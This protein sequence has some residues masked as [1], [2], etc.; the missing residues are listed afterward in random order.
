MF[1]SPIGI[2]Y[3]PVVIT[4]PS[5]PLKQTQILLDAMSRSADEE[6]A[7]KNEVMEY[8]HPLFSRISDIGEVQRQMKAQMD[9]RASAMDN[10]SAE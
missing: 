6:K 4:A 1:D 5:K 9:I 7:F 2:G 10:Y 8:L 3:C